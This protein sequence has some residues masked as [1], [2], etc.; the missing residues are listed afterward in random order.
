MK[1]NFIKGKLKEKEEKKNMEQFIMEIGI[2]DFIMD[3]AL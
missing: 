3:K 2:M 1:E